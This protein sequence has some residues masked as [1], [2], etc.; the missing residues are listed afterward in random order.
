MVKTFGKKIQL[1]Q[2]PNIEKYILNIQ[3]GFYFLEESS[4][5]T[6]FHSL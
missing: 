4:Y 3:F 5:K 6:V 1:E 2:I